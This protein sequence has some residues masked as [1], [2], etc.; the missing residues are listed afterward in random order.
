M[1]V[2]WGKTRTMDY[3]MGWDMMFNQGG[4]QFLCILRFIELSG[5]THTLTTW[6]TN[7]WHNIAKVSPGLQQIRCKVHFKLVQ[8]ILGQSVHTWSR[9]RQPSISPSP[10]RCQGFKARDSKLATRDVLNWKVGMPWHQQEHL[11]NACRVKM[12]QVECQVYSR[13]N[14][15][16][17]SKTCENT[18]KHH[19]RQTLD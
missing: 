19:K 10:S 11:A 1:F 12:C 13:F 4:Y 17:M 3:H 2:L 9:W 14:V 8:H 7:R 6:T 16:L 5:E 18:H 15:Q